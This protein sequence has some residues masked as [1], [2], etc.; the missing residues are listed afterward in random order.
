[1]KKALALFLSS[2]MLLGASM[3]V[4]AQNT[5]GYNNKI[6][7]TI[8]KPDTVDRRIGTLKFF[9][10]SPTEDTGLRRGQVEL[11][12]TDYNHVVIFDDLMGSDRTVRRSFC[13]SWPRQSTRWATRAAR[14]AIISSCG[15]CC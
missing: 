10:G 3:A 14:S 11:G 15:R 6:P 1:M 7:D 8:L 12:A 2:L 5:P 9:D 13:H 4:H